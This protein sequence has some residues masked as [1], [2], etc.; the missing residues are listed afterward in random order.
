VE[1]PLDSTIVVNGT[2]YVGWVQTNDTR[3]QLGFDMNRDNHDKMYFNTG[4]FWENSAQQGSWMI[5]PVM[6]AAVDPYIGIEEPAAT[7]AALR[8]W[9]NPASDAFQVGATSGAAPASIDLMDPTGRMIRA[10]TS[11]G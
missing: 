3:M 11:C 9:P 4:V 10:C 2:F 1:Y 7:D 8:I 5:R 6:V